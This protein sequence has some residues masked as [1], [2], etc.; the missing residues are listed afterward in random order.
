MKKILIT[1][2]NSYVGMSLVKWLGK[3]PDKYSIDCISLRNNGWKE[4]EFS[5]Y[6]V[7][8]HVAGIA[9]IKET[10]ENAHLYYRVNRD[11]AYEVSQKAKREG[12][13]QFIFLSS[14]SVYG[15][16]SGVIDKNS[17]LKPKS[18]Y[19]KSKLQAEE[20]IN[21]LGSNEFKIAF[22][23]PPMIYGKGCKGNY[24]RLG[25]LARKLPIFPSIENKRSMIYIG[26]LCEFLRLII[27]ESKSGLFFP[28][29][30]DYVCTSE[31]VKMIAELHGT[32]M[33]MTKLFNLI[34]RLIS[35]STI[36]KVFG[37][38][39]YDKQ[40]DEYKNR[41]TIYDFETSIRLTEK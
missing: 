19:G 11:L 21:P 12:V 25:N 39:V 3:N 35:I 29:N 40:I 13:K 14:M 30:A 26:N 4:K 24:A 28:Q 37:D 18:N 38:L 20:L 8:L 7:V 6:D 33:R 22:I 9:H 16:E 41:Y 2:K 1:G 5:V 32:K 36:K 10:K 17:P 23:R 31:M 27:D 34:L 15:I